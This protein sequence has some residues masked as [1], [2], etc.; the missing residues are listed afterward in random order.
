MS[1][2]G[3]RRPWLRFDGTAVSTSATSA[4]T[5]VYSRGY[6]THDSPLI[7]RSHPIPDTRIQKI[8][9]LALL[10]GVLPEIDPNL[11]ER[12]IGRK[13]R[14]GLGW[15]GSPWPPSPPHPL[16]PARP[17]PRSVAFL[18]LPDYSV[19]RQEE[20]AAPG[21]GVVHAQ[22]LAGC[23][24]RQEEGLIARGPLQLPAEGRQQAHAR[25]LVSLSRPVGAVRCVPMRPRVHPKVASK[26]LGPASVEITL[27][28]HS[29]VLP[30][31]QRK[32]A[33]KLSRLFA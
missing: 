22:E 18:D 9:K 5:G 27:N 11:G 24:A 10:G 17:P 31:L 16:P 33:D 29:R 4:H 3:C 21:R 15:D 25:G 1:V 32:A 8:P 13:V 14:H 23:A 2:S 12:K 26:R 6:P 28:T 30:T 19:V 7:G 20:E